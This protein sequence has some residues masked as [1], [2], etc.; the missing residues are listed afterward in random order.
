MTL[1]GAVL[2][3]QELPMR[4]WVEAELRTLLAAAGALLLLGVPPERLMP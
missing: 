2:E 4:A 3:R 1:D